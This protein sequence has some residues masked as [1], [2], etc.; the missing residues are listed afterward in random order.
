MPTVGKGA[1]AVW[2]RDERVTVWS[3]PPDEPLALRYTSALQGKISKIAKYRTAG[4]V[5]ANEPVIVAMSQGAI[6]DSDL[7]DLDMPLSMK[8]LYGIGDSVLRVD[9][10]ARTSE[11][12]VLHRSEIRNKSGA[13]VSAVIFADPASVAIAGVM[14]ARTSVFNYFGGRRRRLLMAHNPAADAPVPI[15]VLPWR[16][17][18]WVDGNRLAHRGVVGD[19]GPFASPPRNRLPRNRAASPAR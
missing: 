13:A 15:G 1:N 9:P 2:Q 6:R 18:L 8:V 3:G 4:I 7:H 14:I 12:V 19:H 17:E 16:G 5:A 10:Y 11:V